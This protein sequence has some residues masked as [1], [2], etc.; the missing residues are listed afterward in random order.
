MSGS[1]ML[2]NPQLRRFLAVGISNTL[3]CY[4]VYLL[5]LTFSSRNIAYTIAFVCGLSFTTL[6]N[7]RFAFA[8][9]LTLQSVTTYLIYY[10]A[11]WAVSLGAL[12]LLVEGFGIPE[13]LGPAAVLPLSVPPHYILSR[14]ILRR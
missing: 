6:A 7:I 3:I 8:R 14:R 11:Y 4:L 13:A 9:K 1:Q 10:C 2:L 12:K 5:V